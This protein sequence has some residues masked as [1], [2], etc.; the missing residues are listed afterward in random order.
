MTEY[1]IWLICGFLV[2]LT[3]LPGWVAPISWLLAPTW[4]M[5]AIRDSAT[6]EAPWAEI[7]MCFLLGSAYVAAGVLLTNRILHAARE[8][9][10][11]SLT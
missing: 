9:A 1:P 11:L 3:L 2:P 4:G 8:K 6:G 10:S 5:S 7:G